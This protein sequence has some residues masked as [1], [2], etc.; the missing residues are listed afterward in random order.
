MATD[1]NTH[2]LSHFPTEN[3]IKCEQNVIRIG[4]YLYVLHSTVT[5]IATKSKRKKKRK[6]KEQIKNLQSDENNEETEFNTNNDQICGNLEDFEVKPEDA[7]SGTSP[8]EPEIVEVNVTIEKIKEKLDIESKQKCQNQTG[9]HETTAAQHTNIENPVE[10]DMFVALRNRKEKNASI[11]RSKRK[12]PDKRN[13]LFFKCEH[14][15][16]EKLIRRSN[17]SQHMTTHSNERFECDICHSS[18][19]TKNGLRAHFYLHFPKKELKCTICESIFRSESSLSQHVR[20]VHNKEAK[21]FICN[22]CGR[23]LRK[24]HLLK[25]HM[26]KHTGEKPFDCPHDGCEKRFYTK[27]HRNEHIR[28]HTGEKPFKCSEDGCDRQ[29]AYAIDFKRHKF[30]VHGIFTNK[31]TCPICSKVFP[32]NM[33]LKKHLKLHEIHDP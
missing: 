31:F 8:I 15:G 29:F 16:C 25:E 30:K 7:E 5:C 18:L 22:V 26:N 2:I 24:S 3:C 33:L 23:A 13:D 19:A 6:S 28:S 32:E 1:K 17:R 20:F 21:R 9:P 12:R 14:N 11:D 27:S 4:E 10:Q